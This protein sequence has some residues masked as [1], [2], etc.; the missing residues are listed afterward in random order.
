MDE[1]PP[2]RSLWFAD[3]T[4]VGFAREPVALSRIAG[5]ARANHVLPRGITTPITRDD[6]IQIEFTAIENLAA[7]LARVLVALEH[8]M[9]GKFNFLLWEPIEN[10]KHN[11]PRDTDLERDRSDDFVVGRVGRQIAPAF[12]IV[13]HEIVRLVRRNNVGVSRIH[14]R[15]GATRRTDVDRLPQAVKHQNLIVEHGMQ[16]SVGLRLLRTSA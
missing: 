9:P 7:V 4:H 16:I 2:F 10:Q 15:E 12:E 13:R 1:R 3:Q 8:V 6:M 14:E 5:D 11:H